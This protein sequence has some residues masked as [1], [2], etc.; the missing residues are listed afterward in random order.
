MPSIHVKTRSRSPW[1]ANLSSEQLFAHHHQQLDRAFRI[2]GLAG[3]FLS[4]ADGFR[5]IVP[6][7][8]ERSEGDGPLVAVANAVLTGAEVAGMT[9]VEAIITDLAETWGA[10]AAAG[11]ATGLGLSRNA[12]AV[13]QLIAMVGGG[14]VGA[15]VG[16]RLKAEVPIYR[17]QR[18]SWGNLVWAPVRPGSAMPLQ[19]AV[20]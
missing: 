8:A 15:A 13:V 5:I 19:F 4:V 10:T 16:T 9:T 6:T 3:E 20:R 11:A 18:D 14:L 12:T 1:L 7:A 2:R 17:L